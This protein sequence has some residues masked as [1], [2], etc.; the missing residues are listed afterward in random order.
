MVT[1][2]LIKN[3][4]LNELINLNSYYYWYGKGIHKMTS[5]PVLSC[6]R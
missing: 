4:K 5:I 1:Q 6:I 3:V 2:R